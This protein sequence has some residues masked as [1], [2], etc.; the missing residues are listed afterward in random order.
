MPLVPPYIESLRPYEAGRTIESV[1]KQY[2]LE[3]IAK[4]ASNENPLGPSTKAVE[5][6]SRT[7]WLVALM[8]VPIAIFMKHL[9]QWAAYPNRGAV[10]EALQH[11]LI[12]LEQAIHIKT[13]KL[14]NFFGL[15]DTGEIKAGRRADVV[16][17]NLDEIAY[18]DMEKRFDVPDG[19]GGTTWRFTRQAAPMRLTLVNGVKTFADGQYTGKRPGTYLAPTEAAAEQ[20]A[21]EAAE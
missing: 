13:G 15:H 6:M 5:A 21:L 11:H 19:D 2:G 10:A 12:S 4:L 1:R 16:V 7:L 3:R 20:R 14:A 9:Y 8:F 18:R 17:F